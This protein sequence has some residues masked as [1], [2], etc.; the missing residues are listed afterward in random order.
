MERLLHHHARQHLARRGEESQ[1]IEASFK[2]RHRLGAVEDVLS[3]RRVDQASEQA[4]PPRQ[5]LR[6][7]SACNAPG[8]IHAVHRTRCRLHVQGK[9]KHSAFSLHFSHRRTLPWI[10]RQRGGNPSGPQSAEARTILERE[11]ASLRP[12]QN[13]C[14]GLGVVG[15]CH[16]ICRCVPRHFG[17]A[18]VLLDPRACAVRGFLVWQ[19]PWL[20]DFGVVQNGEGHL[21]RHSIAGHSSDHFWGRH[22]S[23]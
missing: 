10:V 19:R 16:R 9:R 21:H 14:G 1:A 6:S 22:H 11:V 23:I 5:C 20:G 2:G 7:T 12:R 18:A 4:I 17:H 3:A 15:A 13:G 8:W